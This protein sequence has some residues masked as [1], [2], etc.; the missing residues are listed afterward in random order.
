MIQDIGNYIHQLGLPMLEKKGQHWNFRCIVCNDSQKN[1]Y[2]KRGWILDKNGNFFYYC[3]NCG[4]SLKFTTFLKQYYH[5][6]YLEY[7]KETFITKKT[8]IVDDIPKEKKIIFPIDN[9]IPLYKLP[10]NHICSEYVK[11]RKIPF[12]YYKILY[13]CP[14]F[15]KEINDL[16]PEK[17][18]NYPKNDERL[19]IP[20]F[21]KKGKIPYIQ[22]RT[23]N[24]SCLRYATI[25]LLSD[26]PK[27]YGLDRIDISKI[28]Q[29][30]EGPL[31]SLFLD[32]AIAMGSSSINF[33]DLLNISNKQN[34]VFIFDLESKNIQICNKIE[35]V[36]DN[37]FQICL[38]PHKFKIYGKD[39]NQFIESGLSRNKIQNIIQN[40]IFSGFKAKVKFK[41]WKQC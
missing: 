17:F 31:D 6:I 41:L 13:Y 26:Y 12:K 24:G 3:H 16:F 5:H 29:I 4:V 36:I 7:V 23:I 2:K 21:D 34:F 20:F 32:N 27:I 25:N 30:V 37:G 15:Q 1:E 11:T 8:K 14:N 39:I 40:N 33:D 18:Q 10:K 22:G 19:I 35:K 28:I 9:I 38:M